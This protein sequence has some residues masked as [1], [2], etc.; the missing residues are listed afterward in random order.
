VT[1]D[2]RGWAVVEPAAVERK[3]ATK[4]WGWANIL[5]WYGN[6]VFFSRVIGES[7]G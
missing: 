2:H 3:I 7:G 6:H 4:R 5:N 1:V